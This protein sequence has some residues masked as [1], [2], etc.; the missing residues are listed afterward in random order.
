MAHIFWD[1]L[2]LSMP[3]TFSNQPS[4]NYLNRRLFYIHGTH[5]FFVFNP[6]IAFLMGSFYNLLGISYFCRRFLFPYIL[7]PFFI[8]HAKDMSKS[9][10]DPLFI[11]S[12]VLCPWGPWF[13]RI[14]TLNVSKF[15]SKMDVL[16]RPKEISSNSCKL[17]FLFMVASSLKFLVCIAY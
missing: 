10:S 6:C 5:D 9:S 2:L 15:P 11:P 7:R 4:L 13:Y 1:H 14:Q 8:I 17:V 16:P 12:F 3:R